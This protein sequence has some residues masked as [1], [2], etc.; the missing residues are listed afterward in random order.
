[1]D[2]LEDELKHYCARLAESVF[3]NART[4]EYR[5][6]LIW[7]KNNKADFPIIS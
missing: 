7:Q 3:I 2:R 5:N 4:K 1:M 6:P